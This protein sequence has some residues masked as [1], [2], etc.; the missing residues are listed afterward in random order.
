MLFW[1]ASGLV[2]VFVVEL[3]FLAV[4]TCHTSPESLT[5][6]VKLELYRTSRE[7]RAAR[8]LLALALTCFRLF[9]LAYSLVPYTINM[10]RQLV[11]VSSLLSVVRDHVNAF[12]R[13]R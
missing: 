12:T 2:V 13:R 8:V 1:Y 6:F 4:R 5:Y 7:L 10:S 9:T 11:F 3:A